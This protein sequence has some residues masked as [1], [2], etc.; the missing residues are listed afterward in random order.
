M[1]FRRL[2]PAAVA[3]VVAAGLIYYYYRDSG[4]LDGTIRTSGH[5]EVTEVD[6]SFR[7][8]GHVAKILVQEGDTVTAD[9]EVARLDQSVLQARRD[10][11]AAQAAELE[12]RLASTDLSIRIKQETID[13]Q[14]AQAEAG[15]A[16][17]EAR[18]E[19]LKSG[20]RYQE[21]NEAAAAVDMAKAEFANRES[22]YN[23]F[24]RLYEGKIISASQYDDARAAYEAARASLEAAEQRYRLVKAGPRREAVDEG[25]ANLTGQD[26]YLQSAKVSRQEVERLKLDRQA[27]SAQLD[28]A[29]AALILAEDDLAHAVLYAPFAG[30]V[31]VKNVE[32]GEFV[33]AGTPVITVAQTMEVWVK[34]YVPETQLG[35]IKLGQGAE[36]ISDSFPGKIYPGT[37]TYISPK[38]EFTPKNVQTEE[39]RVKLVY[40]L[41][42]TVD[43]PDQ[44]LKAGMPVDVV[45]R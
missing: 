13:A 20:S 37:V 31:T 30:F 32:E 14:V 1:N 39:E 41:K 22:N 5:I 16:A 34:T 45:L 42:V 28:Q 15:V 23:R 8:A 29:R 33:Q 40:R 38:A 9:Q 35:R 3:I 18:Y 2:I 25:K 19:S 26:A 11:A 10:Q 6:L 27:G 21:I 4:G 24:K 44:E 17:A 36:V 12:A 43:N 7:S